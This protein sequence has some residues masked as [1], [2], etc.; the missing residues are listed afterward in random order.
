[1]SKASRI[2]AVIAVAVIGGVGVRMSMRRPPAPPP[3]DLAPAPPDEAATKFAAQLAQA[4]GFIKDGRLADAGALLEGALAR[5]PVDPD[6]Y[7][8]LALVYE[9]TGKLDAA[10]SA[11]Q[12]QLAL[13]GRA[14]TARWQLG[15]LLL[16]RNK[17]EDATRELDRAVRLEP[18]SARF[19]ADLAKAHYLSRRIDLARS[20]FVDALKL[21]PSV[22]DA[23]LGLAACNQVDEDFDGA[24]REYLTALGLGA[25]ANENLRAAVEQTLASLQQ[26]GAD[27][28]AAATTYATKALQYFPE[29]ATLRQVAGQLG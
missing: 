1:M 8:R 12:A 3:A 17:L 23:H 11:Y 7:E 22:V 27:S 13:V 29:S 2:V 21:D 19:R 9:R 25:Q 28:A 5:G 16:R 15:K 10:V 4:D 18:Q 14:P 20:E 24:A 26:R 6:L